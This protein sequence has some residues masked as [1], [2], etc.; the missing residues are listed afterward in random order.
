[1]ARKK[2]TT[3]NT[4]FVKKKKSRDPSFKKVVKVANPTYKV[5]PLS[6][7]PVGSPSEAS[8]YV[9]VPKL[10]GIANHRLY[11]ESRTYTVKVNLEESASGFGS[12][13]VYALAPTWYLY[14]AIRTAREAY[15]K[16]T[17]QERALIK[18]ARWNDF[19][20]QGIGNCFGGGSLEANVQGKNLLTGTLEDMTIGTGEYL[21]SRIENENGNEFEFILHDSTN[22][23]RYNILEEYDNMKNV[24][25]DPANPVAG[26]YDGLT[27]S[28]QIENMASMQSDGNVPPYHPTVLPRNLLVKVGTLFRNT[29]GTQKLS[30]GFFEAPLGAV[31]IERT[32]VTNPGVNQFT[33]ECKSG[34][35]KGVAS[36]AI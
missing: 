6:H 32:G 9:P 23:T 27:G 12:Y 22:S 3:N 29:D 18:G 15:M 26:G 19:R 34:Q 14:G 35:Y 25:L 16:A 21:H 5:L 11:R 24:N 8:I 10:L 17:E 13:P 30:T 7:G 4:K 2:T 28:I 20:L 33:L 1:M 36:D 31:W